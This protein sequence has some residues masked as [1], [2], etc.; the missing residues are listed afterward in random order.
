AV[1]RVVAARGRR[2]RGA[3]LA[4]LGAGLRDGVG[5]G[6]PALALASRSHGRGDALAAADVRLEALDLREVRVDAGGLLLGQ[7]AAFR[8]GGL[9]ELLVRAGQVADARAQF[10]KV[11][12][13]APS[14][15]R[16]ASRRSNRGCPSR[17]YGWERRA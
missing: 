5:R 7:L 16:G 14:K 13:R 1:A 3:A 15:G 17:N 10:L 12:L 2:N 8:V 9:D 4:A 6:A 11:H